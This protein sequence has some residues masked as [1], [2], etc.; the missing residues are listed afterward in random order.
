MK[1]I[2]QNARTGV[3]EIVDV[4]APLPGLGQI[5]VRNHF[6]VVSPGTET[7]AMDFARKSLMEK[8]RSRPDLVRQVLRKLREEGPSATYQTV[9]NRLD[10][11]QSLG[12]SSAGVVVAVGE[13]V[14]G[15]RVGD[16][17]ACGGAGYANHAEIVVVPESLA[18]AIPDGVRTDQA[19][20]ATIGAIALQGVRIADPT[21]GETGVVVGLGVIGQLTVQ[22]LR[23]N[24]CRVLGVD[25]QDSRV[26]QALDLGAEWAS[27]PDAIP[28]SWKQSVNGG[29][30]A[31]FVVVAASAKSAAPLQLA[32]ELARPRARIVVV[33]AV[34]MSLDRRSFY[35]KELELRM[36]MS[37]GPGRYD[38]AFEE[39]GLDYPLSYVRWTENRNLGAFLQLVRQG[40]V[41]IEA[42]DPK[43]HPFAEAVPTYEAMA[44][45]GSSDLV[46][47]FR[48][49]EASAAVASIPIAPTR[50][51]RRRGDVGVAFVGAGNYAKGVLLPALALVS[52]TRKVTLVAATGASARRTAERHG[53]AG[54]S[55]DAASAIDCNDADL[56]F[57]ATR[58]DS[59][60]QLATKALEAG[61]AVWLE[62]P[63]AL[64]AAQLDP[65]LAAATGRFL[66]VGFNRRFSKHARAIREA[67]SKRVGALSIH[68]VVA[69]GP[70]PRNSWITEA[71][72]GGGRIVGEVCHFIDL[73][74]FLVGSPPVSVSAVP[75]GRLGDSDDGH[76]AT[77]CFEDGSVAT[78]EYLTH[79]DRGIPK[80]RFEV[81]AD[82][83]TARCDNFRRT[84][85]TSGSVLR[86]LNQDKGQRTAVREVVEA[87]RDGLP[88]P[89]S[90][91]EIAAATRATFAIC[92]ALRM[93]TTIPIARYVP[94]TERP[95]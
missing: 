91:A 72:V 54:C 6:S 20:F 58:H 65:L 2:I 33:G 47:V 27:S 70:T 29:L 36:S 94:P 17:V 60:A 44:Q 21:I 24:G 76:V 78:I 9:T 3:L 75:I 88:S 31:D 57:I 4:P 49:D 73:C 28:P 51:T 83:R 52:D 92:D 26:K 67:F 89:I 64:H 40:A 19:A 10:A 77:L 42:L 34:P 62:K 12:Y 23:A 61:K 32:A 71:S 1:Q 11:P 45:G 85:I 43:Y 59:H 15:L 80:E 56:V 41:R 66:F 46:V 87:V 7:L 25:L 82:G 14:S 84:A 16:R 93:S 90:L 38:R 37:Y 68:Y 69:A 53:F 13:G 30:G 74:Q 39:H 8:A 18:V 48:Y 22:I 35:E 86:S 5:Q 81:S 63:A 55:T 50:S 79:T 95:T